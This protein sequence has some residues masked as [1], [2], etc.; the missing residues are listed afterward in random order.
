M[1]IEVAL[2]IV[3][4]AVELAK[5]ENTRGPAAKATVAETLIELVRAAAQAY[6]EHMG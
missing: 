1:D 4:I 5:A 3:G 6:H 2:E